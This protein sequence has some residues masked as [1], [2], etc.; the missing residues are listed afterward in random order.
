MKP[1]IIAEDTSTPK[2][3]LDSEK[4]KFEI[5]GVSLPEDVMSFYEPVFSWINEYKK[6]PNSQTEFIFRLNY[7]NSASSKIILDILTSLEE[8]AVKGHSVEI[9]WHYLEID[10]DMLATG[11]EFEEML[12]IP[13]NYIP[14]L[15]G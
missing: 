2:V 15:Q 6:N 10:E 5:S 11:K 1:L 9:Q 7:F 4:G 13:F 14:F 3:I 12:K 8:I